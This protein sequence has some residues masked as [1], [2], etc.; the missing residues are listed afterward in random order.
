M[1]VTHMFC[2]TRVSYGYKVYVT[3]ALRR[4][5]DNA[6]PRVI[7]LYSLDNGVARHWYSTDGSFR[8]GHSC[9]T[10]GWPGAAYHRDEVHVTTPD[11]K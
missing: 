5:D 1:A 4:N 9:N 11:N 8:P 10:V 3:T 2:Y 6:S 7:A